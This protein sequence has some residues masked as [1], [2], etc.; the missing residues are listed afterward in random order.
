MMKPM[1]G[2]MLNTIIRSGKE[3]NTRTALKTL[4]MLVIL[5]AVLMT[6]CDL[7]YLGFRDTTKG[8]LKISVNADRFSVSRSILPETDMTPA[9][10]HITGNG[11]AGATFIKVSTGSAINV[12]DLVIG[13]WTITVAAYN[14]YDQQIGWGESAVLVTASTISD[15]SVLV[16]PYTGKGSVAFSVSWDEADVSDPSITAVL[17][18][19]AGIETDLP[20]S[21]GTGTATYSNDD[22]GAGYLHPKC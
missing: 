4:L 17:T 13:S 11:P 16:E 22:V 7:S 19:A 12:F 10:Y 14:S 8:A 5:S 15:T 18:D 21:M 3:K 2:S 20:F 1:E 9:E 6:S